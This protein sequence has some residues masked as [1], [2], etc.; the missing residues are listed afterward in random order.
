MAKT[1]LTATLPTG[2]IV[3]RTTA[4]T[5]THIV[6]SETRYEDQEPRL[7]AVEWAGRLDLAQKNQAKWTK[8]WAKQVGVSYSWGTLAEFTVHI[9]PVNA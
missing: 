3:T 7:E 9:I 5:Y 4:R 1:T 6:V 2:E 8:N